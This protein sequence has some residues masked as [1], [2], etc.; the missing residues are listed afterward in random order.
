[1]NGGY[2]Y[3][4]SNMFG[5]IL[6]GITNSKSSVTYKNAFYEAKRLVDSGKPAYL[7]YGGIISSVS[8]I[9]ANETSIAMYIVL[10][11]IK[12]LNF[13]PSTPDTITIN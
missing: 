1:M 5:A 2:I 6:D 7:K 9:G 11:S 12:F 3:G 4:D 8:T 10:D 13:T